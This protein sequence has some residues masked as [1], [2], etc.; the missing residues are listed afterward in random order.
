MKNVKKLLRNTF[1]REKLENYIRYPEATFSTNAAERPS[2]MVLL[3]K[4]I[5]DVILKKPLMLKLKMTGENFSPGILKLLHIKFVE[6]GFK[7]WYNYVNV[8]SICGYSITLLNNSSF[9]DGVFCKTIQGYYR[10]AGVSSNSTSARR[11]YL[12]Y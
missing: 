4:I 3:L 10:H 7:L 2:R 12:W 1:S 9:S 5:S 11:L 6:N 8:N